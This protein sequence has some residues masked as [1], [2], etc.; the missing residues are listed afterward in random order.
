MMGKALGANQSYGQRK[1]QRQK[2]ETRE[3]LQ[4]SAG[5]VWARRRLCAENRGKGKWE[6][7]G[8]T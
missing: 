3:H 8:R 7:R 5:A 2:P 4:H 1:Q 6:G